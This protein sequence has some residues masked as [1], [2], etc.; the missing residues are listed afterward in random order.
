MSKKDTL[1]DIEHEKLIDA[2]FVDR[3]IVEALS[4]PMDGWIESVWYGNRWKKDGKFDIAY[5]NPEGQYHR[6]FGPAYISE[7]YDYEI[8]YKNGVYHREDGPAIRHRNNFVWYKEGQLHNLN[9]PAIINGGGP[10]EY[11]IDGRKYSPKEYKKETD[12]RRR[13]GLIE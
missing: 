6:L 13:K 8:W 5:K 9:G 12:R 7:T 1:E 3:V 10:K 4:P 2:L 11:Y